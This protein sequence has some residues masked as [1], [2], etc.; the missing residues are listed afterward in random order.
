MKNAQL[1]ALKLIL[2]FLSGLALLSLFAFQVMLGL[3][4][5]EAVQMLVLTSAVASF[6][7]SAHGAYKMAP[8]AGGAP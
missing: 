5:A 4:M 7:I 3:K 1:Q 6:G 8:P 2:G